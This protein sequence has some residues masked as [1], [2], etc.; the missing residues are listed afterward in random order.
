MVDVG[1][2]RGAWARAAL[3]HGVEDVL[4]IDGPWVDRTR[5]AVPPDRFR[6]TDLA[7]IADVG[8][9]FELAISLEVAEHLPPDASE[10]HVRLLVGA[11]PI[12]VFSAAVPGQGGIGH[13]NERWPADW[14]ALFAR[15]GYEVVDCLR[16]MLWSADDVQW[17][18]AQN[19]L[20]FGDPAALGA[21]PALRDH[22]QRGV[23]PL[24]LVH[25][26]R[27]ANPA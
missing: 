4:A 12:V 7:E 6:A 23:E 21:N 27:L 2:G 18:Y 19:M 1:S 3:D 14:A 17:W 5:L 24:P 22:P 11:A 25:P 10:R 26:G 20:L 13:V 8:R 15:H 9:R 16:P